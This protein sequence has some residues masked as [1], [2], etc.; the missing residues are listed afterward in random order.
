MSPQRWKD[1]KSNAMTAHFL[2]LVFKARSVLVALPLLLALFIIRREHQNDLVIAI[3]G[4]ILF[5]A[6]LILRIWS[7][8]HIHYRLRVE[9]ILTTT[10]PYALVR[11]PIYIGNTLLCLG[12]TVGSGVLWVAPITLAI[13]C[14]VYGTVVR[15]EE[16]CLIIKFSEP[17]V[18]YCRQVPR[19]FPRWNGLSKLRWSGHYLG[20]S[21][22]AEVYNLLFILPLVLKRI[23]S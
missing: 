3:G 18:E 22:L 4:G 9:R 6:G 1:G 14:L 17:Y 15:Y 12:L 5:L 11:N 2:H 21:L 8:Q 13:C 16:H 20:A 19:W 10:G 7:Q 23:L